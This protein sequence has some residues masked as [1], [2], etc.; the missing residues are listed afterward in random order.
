MRAFPQEFWIYYIYKASMGSGQN[1]LLVWPCRSAGGG[2][3]TYS[4]AGFF[5]RAIFPCCI[6]KEQWILVFK[7]STR[8]FEWCPPSI[9]RRTFSLWTQMLMFILAG[10]NFLLPFIRKWTLSSSKCSQG[11][12]FSKENSVDNRVGVQRPDLL[13]AQTDLEVAP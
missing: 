4:L 11:S 13:N 7:W 2:A 9:I 3:L 10:L 5:R 12:L 8:F 6:N 1:I